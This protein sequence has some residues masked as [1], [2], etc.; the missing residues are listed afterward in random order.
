VRLRTIKDGFEDGEVL[1]DDYNSLLGWQDDTKRFVFWSLVV[2][3]WIF[4]RI[5]GD[6]NEG[7]SGLN[8]YEGVQLYI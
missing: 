5:V 4:S 3:S 1:G 2:E 7:L 6:G 8:S